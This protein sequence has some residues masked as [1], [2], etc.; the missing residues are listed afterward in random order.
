MHTTATPYK[1]SKIFFAQKSTWHNHDSLKVDTFNTRGQLVPRSAPQHLSVVRSYLKSQSLWLYSFDS[2]F[3]KKVS[4]VVQLLH[5]D[6]SYCESYKDRIRVCANSLN[7]LESGSGQFKGFS[8]DI[9]DVCTKF[10]HVLKESGTNC[11]CDQSYSMPK[12][13]WRI[14][15]HPWV[16]LLNVM[17][18]LCPAK[19]VNR[20]KHNIMSTHVSLANWS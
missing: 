17:W 10:L 12:G 20:K 7:Q 6:S 11:C 13:S 14:D 18:A 19:H 2:S 15:M 1:S 9:F 4:R 5:R 8:F 3:F 16:L